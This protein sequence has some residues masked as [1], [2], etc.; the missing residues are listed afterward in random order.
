[1]SVPVGAAT[2]GFV[3]EAPLAR[4]RGLVVAGAVVTVLVAGSV[5]YALGVV[6][7]TAQT[8]GAPAPGTSP[9]NSPASPGPPV[10]AATGTS[11]SSATPRVR[12]IRGPFFATN[13]VCAHTRCT[14]L[15][16]VNGVRTTRG[17]LRV[18]VIG[19]P[20]PGTYQYDPTLQPVYIALY[21]ETG[22]AIYTTPKA[23][24]GAFMPTSHGPVPGGLA[25]DKAGRVFVPFD[26]AAHSS[27]LVVLDPNGP[28]VRDF[29]SLPTSPDSQGS[30][31]ADTPFASARDVDGDG[32]NEIVL[33]ENDYNP[34]YVTGTTRA[35][36]FR[37]R[38]GR[39]PLIGC[40]VV[41]READYANGPDGPPS[42]RTCGPG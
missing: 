22:T 40:R 1:M 34:D 30:F 21:D 12:T 39:W 17:R 41:R 6:S 14:L 31:F 3:S 20:I 38:N 33:Y 15:G 4:R 2:G 42:P 9:L 13:P 37:Y 11:G 16:S 10:P 36:F 24:T 5:G 26:V 23:I 32:V 7:G 18:E 27:E 28:V 35:R 8:G 29:D 25:T 19:L